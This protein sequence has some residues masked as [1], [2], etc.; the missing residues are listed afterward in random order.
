MRIAIFGDVSGHLN[1]FLDGLETVGVKPDVRWPDDLTVIQVGDLVHKGPDSSEI[2]ATVTKLAAAAGPTRWIQLAGNHEGTYLGAPRFGTEVLG[3]EDTKVLHQWHKTGFLRAAAA[4]RTVDGPWL[5]S[6][7]GLTRWW[8]ENR[9][10]RSR[11]TKKVAA[12]LNDL[13]RA[14]PKAFVAGRMLAAHNSQASPLWAHPT[15]EL[16]PDWC[17]HNDLPFSQVH[18]HASA[19]WWERGQW[20]TPPPPPERVVHVDRQAR[21]VSLL[22]DDQFI[23]GVD[24]GYSGH[25]SRPLYPLVFPDARLF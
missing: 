22:V 16:W 14:N 3:S 19:F 25:A 15:A 12:N 6:H 18:G 13:W 11:D 17:A 10:N 8:W 5:V 24:P 2:L 21:T 7:A 4:F 23:I 9:C 1:P 20:S